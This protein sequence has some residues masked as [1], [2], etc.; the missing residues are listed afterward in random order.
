MNYLNQVRPS[1]PQTANTKL[2]VSTFPPSLASRAQ[3]A[4]HMNFWCL[5]E[6]KST[7]RTSRSIVLK[8]STRRPRIRPNPFTRTILK[9]YFNVFT[10]QLWKWSRKFETFEEL[11]VPLTSV[12]A[13]RFNAAYFLKKWFPPHC[14]RLF[15]SGFIEESLRPP[16][17]V[18]AK[19]EQC[20]PHS[21]IFS[22]VHRFVEKYCI[23]S[24]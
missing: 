6:T 8:C 20:S 10:M 7:S 13:N 24:A 4:M 18:Q 16:S 22:E 21:C 11:I 23:C 9:G 1:L 17:P 2:L 14:T 12:I 19:C 15:L 5:F 3:N